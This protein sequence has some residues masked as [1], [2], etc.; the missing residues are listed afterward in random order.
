MNRK[1]ILEAVKD[2]NK[3]IEHIHNEMKR[4]IK[5]SNNDPEIIKIYQAFH[6]KYMILWLDNEYFMKDDQ[7]DKKFEQYTVDKLL[8]FF[9]SVK[10][11]KII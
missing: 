5:E 7:V 2:V 11:N 1:L 6:A 9:K 3:L 10:I 8:D 4:I